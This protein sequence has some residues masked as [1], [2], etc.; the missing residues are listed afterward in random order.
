MALHCH[1]GR[2]LA[3]TLIRRSACATSCALVFLLA[4]AVPTALHAQPEAYLQEMPS[5][6]R[7]IADISGRDAMDSR[8]RRIAALSRLFD[9][10]KDM[11]GTRYSTGPF[12]NA[13][14]KPLRDGY[15]AAIT[16]LRAE[17][18]ATFPAGPT[19]LD[20]PR[21]RWV[22][23]IE[24]HQRSQELHDELMQRYFSPATQTRLQG[25]LQAR[26]ARSA[27]GAAAIRQGIRELSG[28]SESRWERQSSEEKQGAIT[29]G[30]L[31]IGLLLF[32]A[33][34]EC[35]R[36]AVVEGQPPSIRAG[37]GRRRLAWVT[38]TVSGHRWHDR[39]STTIEERRLPNGEVKQTATTTTW[40][41]EDF[42]IDHAGGQRHV[43]VSYHPSHEH[44]PTGYGA[45][46]GQPI[47]AVWSDGRWRRSTSY[48]AFFSPS[49][50]TAIS[51][52]ATA[53]TLDRLLSPLRW[54]VLP[55]MGLGFV[56]GSAT[57]SLGSLIPFDAANF[58]GFTVAVLAVVPW[59]IVHLA[60]GLVRRR[61]FANVEMPRLHALVHGTPVE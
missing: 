7:V 55:A 13:A 1:S 16:R 14:E 22:S 29:F 3:I 30:A 32:G 58:R 4:C 21:A 2:S 11:A 31:M 52:P 35:L 60:I 18:M 54:T 51:D 45:L 56:I 42:D 36:F 41:T 59:L 50:P 47:T 25:T 61:R 38:G 49:L 12:P 57:D 10:I 40:R 34:R 19:S 33:V 37:F 15:L 17:G 43:T 6:D 20:S 28:V 26:G 39:S 5:A 23:S 53:A 48:L 9:V 24:A 27:A 8:A 46:T 44:P